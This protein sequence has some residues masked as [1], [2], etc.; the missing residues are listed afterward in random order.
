MNT[1]SLNHHPSTNRSVNVSD[2]V[3]VEPTLVGPVQL[4]ALI[5]R[6]SKYHY[7][8]RSKEPF[9]VH[10]RDY[11]DGYCVC[12]NDNHYRISDLCF[13]VRI[14]ERWMALS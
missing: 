4:Y 11:P 12:G 1:P 10:L 5:K 2:P 9:E 14:G 6:S 8:Q 3:F 13:Y 7:Q